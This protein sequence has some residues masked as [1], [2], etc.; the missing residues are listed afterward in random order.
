[1]K[2]I[3]VLHI[4]NTG[5]FSGAENVAIST[6]CSLSEYI[7]SIY[8]C[9]FGTIVDVLN[10]KNI[11]YICLKK[12]SVN[13][14]KRIIKNNKPDIIHAHDYT[15]GV[16]CALTFTKV[17]IINHIHNNA[18]WIRSVGI[19][20]LLYLACYSRFKCI[21]SVSNSIVNEYVFGKKI[22]NKV[23]VL[24][25][26]ID[27][28]SIR[29]LSL[30]RNDTFYD[31]AYLGRLSEAKNPR[32][33]VSVVEKVIG[34]SPIIKAVMIGDGE[35]KEEIEDLISEKKLEPSI[36]MIGFQKNPF[37]ILKNIK[38]LCMP[39]KWEGYGLAA[40]E[41]MALGVPVVAS[42]VGGLVDIIDETCGYLCTSEDEM[43]ERINSIL[44][45]AELR[46]KL[47]FGSIKRIDELYSNYDFYQL[48]LNK[49][50]E[51]LN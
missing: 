38:V 42:R 28:K 17:P 11:K 32:S 14:I 16:L 6:I 36:E 15:A 49:Y 25:N 4:V 26:P 31:I 51:V 48:I 9:L 12:L 22:K 2:K 8:V 23:T 27:I 13:A 35:L 1:M 21:V 45:D 33:F 39:S 30:F 18:P 7:E 43:A 29:E 47:S 40:A 41:A 19:K 46:K 44:I 37:P 24:R 20:S 50:H 5:K 10:E 3:K 34:M